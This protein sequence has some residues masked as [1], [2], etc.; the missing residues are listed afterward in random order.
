MQ[1]FTLIKPKK[2]PVIRDKTTTFRQSESMA[3][4]TWKVKN[5]QSLDNTM[6]FNEQE[7]K[8]L[9][10]H[11]ESFYNTDDELRRMQTKIQLLEQENERLERILPS[12]LSAAEIIQ[13]T[14]PLLPVQEHTRRKQGS[15]LKIPFV[16]KEAPTSSMNRIAVWKYASGAWEYE[17]CE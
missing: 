8:R 16:D 4:T 15:I 2:D 10:N 17:R 1:L 9:H 3:A 14:R 12:T 11:I 6:N 5:K 7:I 13:L